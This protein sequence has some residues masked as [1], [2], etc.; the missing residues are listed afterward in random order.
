[1]VKL[2][3]LGDY[4]EVNMTVVIRGRRGF[5]C[6][7]VIIYFRRR[8]V[9]VKDSLLKRCGDIINLREMGMV[10]LNGCCFF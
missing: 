3:G 9:L 1:M 10:I 6:I 4:L 2:E 5:S 7:M 8:L